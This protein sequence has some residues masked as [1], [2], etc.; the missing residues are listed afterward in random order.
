MS[1]SISFF[2]LV[3]FYKPCR[4]VE[5]T[6]ISI[7]NSTTLKICHI[8]KEKQKKEFT[9]I[10]TKGK[11]TIGWLFNFKLHIIIN[12][13]GEILCSVIIQGN[14]DDSEPLNYD[15]FIKSVFGKLNA[16]RGYISQTF[17]DIFLL[18]AFI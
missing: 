3:L 17:R 1:Y 14:V 6:E 9:S 10:D 4:I 11:N 18:I 15:T 16:A 5:C 13:K 12:D 2:P 8:K 7:V